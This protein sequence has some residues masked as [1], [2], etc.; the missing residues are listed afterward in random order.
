VTSRPL[1]LLLCTLLSGALGCTRGAA[2]ASGPRPPAAPQAPQPRR[3]LAAPPPC[4]GGLPGRPHQLAERA[5]AALDDGRAGD[6]LACADQALRH[7]PRHLAAL[8]RRAQALAALERVPEARTAFAQVLALDP[9]EPGALA[10]AAALYLDGADPDR[11]ALELGRAYALRGL[12]F[13]KR[14]SDP[15]AAAARLRTLAARAEN[16]LGDARSA[17]AHADAALRSRPDEPD[18]LY[19][20][21]VALYELCR[22]R[23]A[24]AAFQGVLAVDPD[25]PWALH[26]LALVEEHAGDAHRAEALAARARQLAPGELPVAL[27]VD[28]AAFELEV[29]RAVAALPAHERSALREVPVEVADLP[30]VEDLVAVDPPLSPSILGLFRGPSEHEECLPEDGPRCRSIV[31]YRR[32]LV[33]F[34]RSRP[35]LSEQVRVT[36]LHELGHLHGESDDDLRARGLD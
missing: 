20:R 21:G 24:R 10:G 22:F 27:D 32:N 4:P 13:T 29:R 23:E 34:A 12:T 2:P 3:I 9:D 11:A 33:R 7:A 35:E 15:A 8:L 16:G 28:R 36:L 17:L 18:A 19:E 26:H 1:R 6:A 14:A 30:A 25:D 31:V 5:G